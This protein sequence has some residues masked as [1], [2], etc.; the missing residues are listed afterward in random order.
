M[1][2]PARDARAA[3]R[4]SR[5]LPGMGTSVESLC[6]H[7]AAGPARSLTTPL[8]SWLK[9]QKEKRKLD[10]SRRPSTGSKPPEPDREFALVHEDRDFRVS[11][12]CQVCGFFP[13]LGK[14]YS[15]LHHA[16]RWSI[17]C[18]CQSL[19]GYATRQACLDTWKAAC[20]L[21]RT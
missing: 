17:S 11:P 13:T 19:G 5:P 3:A 16:S 1:K 2:S 6:V 10:L 18:H 7:R 8:D 12:R 15:P 14:R 9:D 4:S 21:A 20:R